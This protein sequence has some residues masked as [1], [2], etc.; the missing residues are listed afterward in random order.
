MLCVNSD[1]VTLWQNE[2]GGKFAETLRLSGEIEYRSKSGGIEC[3][4][5]D[6]NND[7]RQ[8]ALIAYAAMTPQLFFN[9][10]FRSF[11]HA[12]TLD[13]G[14]QH[15]LEVAEQGQ[16]SA[17]LGDF[18]GDGAQDMVL[19]LNNGEI[20]AFFRENDDHEARSVVAALPVT[21]QYKGPVAVTGWMGK[22]CLGAW[23]VLPGVSQAFFGR[24]DAGARDTQM[25]FARRQGTTKRS[26]RGEGD[27]QGGDQA[28]I[29]SVVRFAS[30]LR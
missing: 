6:I 14:E 28:E 11:G 13:L 21:G 9:R 1:G 10:G 24:M 26:G 27:G 19:A 17:C 8:D 3:Q 22:R 18:D 29:W 15:L 16:Q 7:G 20:W 30:N 5:G 4:V 2:G 12:H 23:N 25:A